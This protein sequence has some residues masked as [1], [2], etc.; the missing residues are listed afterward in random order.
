[1]WTIIFDILLVAASVPLILRRFPSFAAIGDVVV[2]IAA[3]IVV[4][5]F[6]SAPRPQYLRVAVATRHQNRGHQNCD[7]QRSCHENS[8]AITV[9]CAGASPPA[10]GFGSKPRPGAYLSGCLDGRS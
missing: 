9:V 5:V 2:G 10:S 1:M 8:G 3:L 6:L 4:S 7:H